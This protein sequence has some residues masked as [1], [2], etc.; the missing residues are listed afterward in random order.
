MKTPVAD[1]VKQ[2]ASESG[3]DIEDVLESQEFFVL[4][5]DYRTARKENQGEV[6]N[7]RELIKEFI[8]SHF[9]Q[10]SPCV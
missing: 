9:E 6:A 7:R 4:L 3:L 8:R 10:T 2:M 5:V 1:Y